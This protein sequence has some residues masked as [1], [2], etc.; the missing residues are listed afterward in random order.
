MHLIAARSTPPPPPLEL[1]VHT[2]PHPCCINPQHTSPAHTPTPHPYVHIRSMPRPPTP[3]PSLR[4][5]LATCARPV[6]LLFHLALLTDRATLPDAHAPA[7]VLT[8]VGAVARARAAAAA[9]GRRRRGR[10]TRRRCGSATWCAAAA[11]FRPARGMLCTEMLVPVLSWQC[12]AAGVE[13]LAATLWPA[14]TLVATADITVER[15]R[16]QRQKQY[17][18]R[19]V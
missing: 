19:S 18:P 11:T 12:P 17:T 4:A 14:R 13:P 10:C 16:W 6:P 1:P 8:R 7:H 2:Q 5:L 3:T 9:A 15:H